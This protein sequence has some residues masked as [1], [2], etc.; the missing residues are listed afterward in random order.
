[1]SSA[2][3][4]LVGC[5]KTKRS[6]RAAAR[7]LY[8]ASDLFRRRRSYAETTGLPWGILSAAAGAISPETVLD[9]Y[10]FT[11]ARRMKT[12]EDPRGW[13]IS[14]IQ[15]AYRLAG[16]L[17]EEGLPDCSGDLTI[18]IHAGIDYV[19]TIELGLPAFPGTIE[20]VHPVAGM[21]IGEQKAHYTVTAEPELA[22]QLSLAI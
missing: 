18:E 6:T 9:P 16:R 15:S 5:T 17:T 22:G 13:A 12:D 10:D 19:R 4:I 11:I 7:D 14:S 1:M 21:M 8:D 20:L 2:D 3:V